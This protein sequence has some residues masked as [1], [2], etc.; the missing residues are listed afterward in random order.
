MWIFENAAVG[1]GFLR[2]GASGAFLFLESAGSESSACLVSWSGVF[3]VCDRSLVLEF[4]GVEILIARECVLCFKDFFH[5][6]RRSR[7]SLVVFM[8]EN[9]ARSGVVSEGIGKFVRL[10]IGKRR[11]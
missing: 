5:I 4:T 7:N 11:I 2:F 3:G 8:K 10:G 9:F 6:F 1:L